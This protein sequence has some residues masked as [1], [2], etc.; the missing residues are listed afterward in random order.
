MPHAENV[1]V[2]NAPTSLDASAD[3]FECAACGDRAYDIFLSDVPDR[4]GVTSKTFTYVRCRGCELIA[5]F[6]R[7]TFAETAS[8]YP[9]SFWR[10]KTEPAARVSLPQRVETWLRSRLIKADFALVEDLFRPGLHMLDVGCSTG[11]FLDLCRTRGIVPHGI[12]LSPAAAEHCRSRGLDVTAGDLVTHD[13]GD[14]KFD[15]VTYNGVLEHITEPAAHL[16]KCRKLLSPGGKLVVLGL[17][18]IESAGF[19]LARRSWMGLD[20]PRHIHQFSQAS[21]ARLLAKTGYVVSRIEPRSPRFNPPSLIASVL[22]ALHRHKFDAHQ[23]QT[24]KNPVGRK[25]ILLALLE[26]S[27]PADWALCQLGLSE[28]LTVVAE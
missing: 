25:A 20:A 5:L 10:T 27:R 16:R 17:P 6:P 9:S 7:P 14:Q 1:S 26:L 4:L 11:D 28:N 18:N 8:F 13:F 22:P 3:R 2:R 19:K 15:V 21:V 12:E 24:G 23:A